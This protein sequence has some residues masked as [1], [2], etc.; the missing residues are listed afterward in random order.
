MS[1]ITLQHRSLAQTGSD[2]SRFRIRC[3][4]INRLLSISKLI[5]ST[6]NSKNRN[7]LHV[8]L[9]SP[10]ILF[11]YLS[12]NTFSFSICLNSC[13]GSIRLKKKSNINQKFI[14]EA[15][16]FCGCTII[17]EDLFR[18]YYPYGS[19]TGTVVGFAGADGGLDG[20]EE[21][22]NSSI[23][24]GSFGIDYSKISLSSLLLL[25]AYSN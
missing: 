18:R 4:Y 12:C 8:E 23:S 21:L 16:E 6:P 10:S 15:R 17:R 3:R 24:L 11:K 9:A 22:F 20:V 7:E 2:S 19:I 13:R 14:S 5:G 25:L 1:W